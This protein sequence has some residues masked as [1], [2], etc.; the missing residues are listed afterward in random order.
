MEQ[1]IEKPQART[2]AILRAQRDG[3]PVDLAG[4]SMVSSPS[5]AA[6]A[7]GTFVSLLA[8]LG[9]KREDEAVYNAQATTE[10]IIRDNPEL[11]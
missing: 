11:Q 10:K 2:E 4:E 6:R 7:L 5:L 9:S 3:T 1:N 8:G